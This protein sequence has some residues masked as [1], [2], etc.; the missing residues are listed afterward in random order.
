MTLNYQTLIEAIAEWF[1]QLFFDPM[2]H[3]V[4]NKQDNKKR[5][6]D[7]KVGLIKSLVDKIKRNTE[8][9]YAMFLK[10]KSNSN[11]INNP[12][13]H[14]YSIIIQEYQSIKKLNNGWFLATNKI[15][16]QSV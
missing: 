15:V 10:F 2:Y 16:T 6:C 9:W 11:T 5:G 4:P 1:M 3:F 14:L 7:K 13:N 12:I 8:K